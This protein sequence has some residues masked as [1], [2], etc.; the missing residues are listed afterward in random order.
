MLT[1]QLSHH[2]SLSLSPQDND[3]VLRVSAQTLIKLERKLLHYH[4]RHHHHHKH[5]KHHE[6][7]QKDEEETENILDS[8]V[9]DDEEV[10][11]RV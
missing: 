5:H 8:K 9:V 1:F 10:E 3:D 6:H 11:N 7:H 2:F 4:G